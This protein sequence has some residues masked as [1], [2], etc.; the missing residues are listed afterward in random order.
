LLDY[1]LSPMGK[2]RSVSSRVR[3]KKENFSPTGVEGAIRGEGRS[4]LLVE[5]K[6]GGKK[7]HEFFLFRAQKGRGEAGSSLAIEEG[8]KITGFRGGKEDTCCRLSSICGE[9]REGEGYS[10]REGAQSPPRRKGGDRHLQGEKGGSRS[11]FLVER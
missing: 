10:L 2:R 3:G 5:K 8:G 1:L 9:V 4:T 7:G 6:E 11:L